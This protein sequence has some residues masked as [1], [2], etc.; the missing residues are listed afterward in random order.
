MERAI[1]N[2]RKKL[3]TIFAL[4]KYQTYSEAKKAVHKLGI[5]TAFEY[6]KL[7][8]YKLDSKLS[9]SPDRFYKNKGWE[10]WH[11][12]LGGIY[13]YKKYEEAKNA[14]RKLGIKNRSEY[15]KRYK[16]D[17]KLP[18]NPKKQYKNSNWIDWYDFLDIEK[19]KNKYS[20][21]K[22][23]Q[24]AVQ[25]LG[26]KTQ[27]E[28]HIRYKEDPK[29]PAIPSS[30]Y[31][32][33]CWIDWYDFLDI[34][35][36]K[37]KY[38]T[39]KKAQQAIQKLGIK[40]QK[41]YNKKYKEDLRLPSNPHEHYKNKGWIG[42][43]AFCGKKKPALIYENYEEVKQA[44]K[45]MGI[46]SQTE[47]HKRYKEN[48]KLLRHPESKYD[49][50]GWTNW[51][52]FLDV[53][54]KS[55]YLTY[56]EAKKA[57]EKLEINTQVE[58]YEKYK[59]DSNLVRNPNRYYKYK[60]WKSWF[61][62]LGKEKRKKPYKTLKEAKNAVQ[63]LGIKTQTE[64]HKRYQEDPKLRYKPEVTYKNKGWVSWYDFLGKKRREK[65]K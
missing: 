53:E 33:L 35:K 8:M 1:V 3:L 55:Y 50:I 15:L 19:P 14:V 29:L 30:K 34:E 13:P 56:N 58:F 18:N 25:K 54:K 45:I 23:A 63:K 42:W 28:Y 27:K 11:Y 6:S 5:K 40:T 21:Y 20:T 12:F 4:K 39:Y 64:Y 44:V 2:M 22:K 9:S 62:F 51:Y 26:I 46:S 65:T 43:Y 57:I 48:P 47:Y 16:E 52:D 10:G 24:Q 49:K 32:D 60:G 7:K 31:K 17:P 38:S 61:D 41:E 37:K 59:N 36:P